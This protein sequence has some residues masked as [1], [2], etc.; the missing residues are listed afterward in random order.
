MNG[1]AKFHFLDVLIVAFYLAL[2]MI[3]GLL[4]SRKRKEDSTEYFLA[5][6]NVGWFAIGVALFTTNISSEHFIGLAGSGAARGIAVGS[7]EW[8]AVFFIILLGWIFAPLYLKAGVFTVPEFLEQR[9]NSSSRMYLASI[10][11]FTYLL[12]KVS[13]T[14]FAGGL[15]FR[16]LLGWDMYTSGIVLVML[17]GI[18]TIVGGLRAV[19]YTSVVQSFFLI[20]GAL[21]LTLLGLRE[22]G[23]LSGLQAQ[24]PADYF[25]IFKPASD[26][27]FPWTGILF[28]APILGIWY[29]CTDQYIVQR[30]LSARNLQQAQRGTIFAGFLK[31]LPVFIL[32]VPGLIAAALFPGV[33]GDEAYTMLLSSSFLPLGI[34][35]LIIGGLLA[36][37]MS[38]LAA[39]FN[40]AATIFTRDFYGYFHPE[41]GERKLVLVGRLATTVMVM[42]AILWIPLTKLITSHIYIYL[43][44]VQAYISPPITAV[45]VGIFWRRINGK[46]A[47][48]AL[49]TGGVLGAL[50][51]ILEILYKTG[52]MHL[53][54]LQ[55]F[56]T[57]NFLHFA[58]FLFLVSSLV[59]VGV[60]FATT[61]ATT[62]G[63]M[64]WESKPAPLGFPDSGM[65]GTLEVG[66]VDRI[67][68]IFSILLMAMVLGLWG[69]FL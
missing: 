64:K 27:D 8:M 31:L 12:T 69:A 33:R 30:V 47:I 32:V 9:F 63:G 61:P 52:Q 41:A 14:L 26:P 24:L 28:G 35:G 66:S 59:M 56:A 50:R 15:L 1:L 19:I 36:A 13:V 7:F 39:S 17:T 53:P 25:S 58:I 55:G 6:R 21:L 37:L 42:S 34:K 62:S 67:N 40:S 23:G 16:S 2:V 20:G 3:I 68:L 46:G 11:I 5:G 29:W 38:S 51:L 65:T 54:L 10:S 57:M 45:F 49:M 4:V 43:Q 60:S 22:V 48:W 44:S 18:Y